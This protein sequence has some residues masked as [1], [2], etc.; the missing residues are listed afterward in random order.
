MTKKNGNHRN[1]Q[2]ILTGD[3]GGT[4]TNFGLFAGEIDSLQLMR[5]ESYTTGDASSASHL[6]EQFLAEAGDAGPVTEACF[7]VAAPVVGGVANIVNLPWVLRE[8]E[9][10]KHFGFRQVHLINDLVAAASSIPFL[11]SDQYEA[12]NEASAPARGNIG[13][14][15]AGTGLGEALLVW[16]GRDYLPVAS[17]GGHKDFAPRNERQW[18]LRLYLGAPYPGHVSVERV[19]SGPGIV[20]IYHF[21]RQESGVPEPDWLRQ[22]FQDA[23]AAEV[24]SETAHAGKDPVCQEALSLFLDAYGA[25]A[26][27]LA[28]QG[29]TVGGLYI[30]G[31]IAPKIENELM[32][33]PFMTAFAAKG[34]MA[35]LLEKMPVRLI[36]D[37]L[38]PLW[39]AAAYG[40]KAADRKQ[41]AD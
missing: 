7:G 4:K 41:G 8:K 18:R 27:N 13:L 15:A 30:A 32:A 39:G 33:G 28:L 35:P 38:A 3:F 26:G 24:V 9:I 25:E 10:R 14:L 2:L 22:R 1:D 31:G 17:E 16:N 36:T 6:I 12:L 40:R 19:V 5:L 11:H 34:R 21:L 23:D 37:P 29:L 20:H